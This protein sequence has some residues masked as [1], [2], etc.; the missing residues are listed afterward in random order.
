MLQY[1]PNFPCAL[2]PRA[3][4]INAITGIIVNGNIKYV[5]ETPYVFDETQNW[6][7]EIQN[8]LLL[9]IME[10]LY[11]SNYLVIR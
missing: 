11:Y 2:S 3:F 8:I 5:D 10:A 6:H 9:L 4:I 7:G 1:S